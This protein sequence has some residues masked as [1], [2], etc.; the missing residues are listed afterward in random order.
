M[1]N[2]RASLIAA[3]LAVLSCAAVLPAR[4][5]F[6]AGMKAY[7][8]GDYET[9]MKEWLPLAEAGNAEAQFRVGRLY[10]LGQGFQPNGK[11]AIYWYSKAIK[12]G[13]ASARFNLAAILDIGELAPQDF[14]RARE[15]YHIGALNNHA[16]SQHNLGLMN[17]TGSGAKPDYVEAYKWFFIASANGEE[18]ADKAIDFFKRFVS[19]EKRKKARDAADIWMNE[20][21]NKKG[22]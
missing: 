16:S 7:E 10:H 2:V 15:Y 12:A 20:N 19:E 6:D 9:A 1:R 22:R 8:A 11:L 17:M 21:S 14:K 3:L 18:L 13:H 4:A 5:D